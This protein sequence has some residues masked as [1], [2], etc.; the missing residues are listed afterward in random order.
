MCT[1]SSLSV[2]AGTCNLSITGLDVDEDVPY[3]FIKVS[4]LGLLHLQYQSR[5]MI[6][7]LVFKRVRCQLDNEEP[8]ELT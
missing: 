5:F 6:P 3:S 8:P 7:F 2:F 4:V 1:V